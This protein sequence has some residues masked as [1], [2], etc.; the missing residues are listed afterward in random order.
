[1]KLVSFKATA[2]IRW[3]SLHNAVDA[4]YKCWPALVDSLGHQAT[5]DNSE[6]A[7]KAQGYLK[8]VQQYKFVAAICTLKDVLPTL[9]KLSVFFMSLLHLWNPW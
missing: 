6:N 1:M 7:A 4:I 9:T 8:Q 5:E 2:P 3:L